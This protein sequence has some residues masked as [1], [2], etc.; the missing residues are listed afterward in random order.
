MPHNPDHLAPGTLLSD[1]YLAGRALGTDGEGVLYIGFDTQR[2]EKV[3][4]KEF[5]PGRLA[6]RNHADGSVRPKDKCELSFKS[7]QSDF[8]DLYR[9]LIKISNSGKLIPV[10]DVFRANQTVYGVMG[11]VGA[12][13]LREYLLT[14]GGELGWAQARPLI[15]QLCTAV[16]RLHTHQ[17]I[18]GGISLD[19][20][21]VDQQD[22]LLLGGCSVMTLRC[23]GGE[24][25]PQLF[26]GYTSP[27]QYDNCGWI[28]PSSDVYSVAAVLYRML[29]GTQPP[30]SSSRHISDNLVAVGDL[31]TSVP[32]YVSAAISRAMELDPKKR[33]GD[34]NLFSAEL[35]DDPNSNTAVFGGVLEEAKETDRSPQ[36]QKG[37]KKWP[38]L[39][40]ACVCLV[41]IGVALV[42]ILPNSGGPSS[43]R[44]QVSVPDPFYVPSF[45]GMYVDTVV[46][47]QDNLSKFSFSIREE[48]SDQYP[49]GVIMDQSPPQGVKMIH[50]G[51]VILTVSKG[52]LEAKMPNLVG[53][54]LEF[55]MQTLSNM[56]IN[57]QVIEVEDD[58]TYTPGIVGKTSI[59]AGDTLN[60]ETDTV[61]VYIGKLPQSSSSSSSSSSSNSSST[62]KGT[63]PAP[64]SEPDFMWG[65]LVERDP[66]AD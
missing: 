29:S 55:A 28:T 7:I 48:F 25:T 37:S 35:L 64:S 27:E 13:T 34:I 2:N 66:N 42:Q 50:K 31:D 3:W 39:L 59:P 6:Q 9:Q 44:E 12:V 33:T 19:T 49:S 15:L 58:D 22:N 63:R 11:I 18:H 20:V 47:N 26:E 45:I 17:L 57:Y 38:I 41:G 10:K 14:K 23:N 46:T 56:K 32:A 43:S 21:L 60:R 53:S 52:T 40:V 61:E 16:D 51:T 5:M 65:G 30:E 36:P 1:R 54:T 24:I 4:I 62:G 8:E